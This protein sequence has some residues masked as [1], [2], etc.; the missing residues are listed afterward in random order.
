[1][2][3]LNNIYAYLKENIDEG[4]LVHSENTAKEAVRLAK[5]FGADEQKAL[6]AGLLHDVAKSKVTGEQ[7]RLASMYDVD[8]D[9]VEAKNPELIHGKL[10]AA[11]IQ[12]QLQI[13]DEDILS[14][15]RWHTTGRANMTLLEKIIYLADLIEPCRNFDGIER[16]RAMAYHNIDRAMLLALEQVIGFVKS[17]GYPLHTKSVEA[18]HYFKEEIQ[19]LDTQIQ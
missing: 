19:K 12:Q 17:Q 13:C 7:C 10:G 5:L 3:D 8:I 2:L 18:Y 4:R 14:A 15:V 6:I 16:I 9:A 1:M 11:M